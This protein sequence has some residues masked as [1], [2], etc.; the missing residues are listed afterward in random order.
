MSN[1]TQT[2]LRLSR[3]RKDGPTEFH[4]T[5][6]PEAAAA[7][8]DRL[9]LSG[10]RKMRLTGAIAPDGRSDWHLTAQLGATVV[11]PCSV[12]LEPVTTRIEEPVERLYLKDFA[13][14]HDGE[15]EMPEDDTQEPLPDAIDL[16]ALA[17]EAL[18]LAVPAFPRA[19]SVDDDAPFEARATPPG[20]TPIDESEDA[21]SPFAALEGLKRKLEE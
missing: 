5:P 11:Q 1:Q 21:E 12:T 16:A 6:S 4:F 19:E 15:V 14:P 17:E 18:A 10:L 20:A 2:R 13:A 8:R 9:G 3:L 7:M